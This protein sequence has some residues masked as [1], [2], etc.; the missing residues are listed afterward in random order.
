MPNWR[1][2]DVWNDALIVAQRETKPRDYIYASEIGKNYWERYQKMMGVQPTNPFDAR[3]LRKFAAGDLFEEVVGMILKKCG[4]LIAEQERVEL[5]ATDKHLRVS[6]RIDFHAGG[7]SNWD[8]AR[9]RVDNED[10]PDAIKN[11]CYKI[12]DKFSKEYPNGLDDKIIEVKSVNSMLFW[13]KK[14]YLLQAYPWHEFQLLTYLLVLKKE[15]KIFYISK[16]DLTVKECEL[17]VTDE[18]KA[19][20]YKDLEEMSHYYNTKTEPPLPD[21]II[22]DERK[23][24]SFSAKK[25]L[26]KI[27]TPEEIDKLMRPYVS[28]LISISSAYKVQLQGAHELNWEYKWSG[29]RDLMTGTDSDE[30]YEEWEQQK[31][32]EARDKDKARKKA[33]MDKLTEI[34]TK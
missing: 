32:V 26:E 12:I 19:K 3:V 24:Y 28:N 22:F 13:A 7:V 15:G 9:K 5:P 10:F 8:E 30:A 25:D 18:L 23:K 21:A 20:Y 27:G 14:D 34:T 16:D 2:E 4:I 1:L 33:F 17:E 6:G 29:Y 11:V 31:N